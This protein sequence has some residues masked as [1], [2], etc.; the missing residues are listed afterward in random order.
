MQIE[1]LRKKKKKIF[2][3]VFVIMKCIWILEAGESHGVLKRF[4]YF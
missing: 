1:Q 2:T 3:M 4:C